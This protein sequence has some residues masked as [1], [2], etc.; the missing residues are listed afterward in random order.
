MSTTGFQ[1][2]EKEQISTLHFPSSEVLNTK[3]E[4]LQRQFELEK[5]MSLGNTEKNKFFITFCDDEGVKKVHTT[6]WSVAEQKIILKG[7]VTI[8]INRILRVDLS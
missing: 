3:E 1:I 4:I 8:P 5:A 7:G 2:I 6:I